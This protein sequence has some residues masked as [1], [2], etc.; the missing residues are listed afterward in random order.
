MT[1][2]IE[3]AIRGGFDR[4]MAPN[5]LQFAGLFVFL[6]LV[7]SLLSVDLSAAM[8]ADYAPAGGAQIDTGPRLGL[9]L[10]VAGAGLFL[11]TVVQLIVMIGAIRTFVSDEREALVGSYFTR[12]IGWVG[13]NVFIG[14]IVFGLVVLLGLVALIL[15]GLFL[16]VSLFFWQFHVAVEDEHFLAGF[17]ASWSLTKGHRLRLFALGVIVVVISMLVSVAG[18]VVDLVAPEIVS[19]VVSA[20]VSGPITVFSLATGAEAYTQ[21]RART[22]DDAGTSSGL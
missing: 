18:S 4:L 3:A 9:P 6:S 10:S 17:A 14:G 2:D 19:L 12:R 21:L 15:P 16:L 20:V 5:G 1:L 13:L 8:Y 7:A 11:L 22:T